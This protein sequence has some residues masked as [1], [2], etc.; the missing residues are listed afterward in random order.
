MRENYPL[1]VYHPR[2]SARMAEIQAHFLDTWP[3]TPVDFTS[4]RLPFVLNQ[5]KSF[6]QPTLDQ[7]A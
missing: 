5:K 3:R 2:L 4:G 6:R 1:L 7:F